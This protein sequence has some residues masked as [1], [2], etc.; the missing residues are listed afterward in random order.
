MW[1]KARVI[2]TIPELRKK[3]LLTLGLLAIYRVGYHITLPMVDQTKLGP[4]GAGQGG[5]ADLINQV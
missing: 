3:I 1:E 4:Q 5:F 2:F